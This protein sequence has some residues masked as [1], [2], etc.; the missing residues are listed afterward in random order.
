MEER[1]QALSLKP[2]EYMRRQ[3]RATPYP[4]EDV[5]GSQREGF[6]RRN[7]ETLTGGAL[8]V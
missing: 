5:D 8:P 1:L 3:I 4:A 6:Y 7:F 2:S